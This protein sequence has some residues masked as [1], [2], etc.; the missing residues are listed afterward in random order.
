MT[1][2]IR[3]GQR[4]L[5]VPG[6]GMRVSRRAVSSGSPPSYWLVFD[7]ANDYIT[8]PSGEGSEP[9]TALF[10]EA[11]IKDNPAVS[12]NKEILGR[13]NF[14]ND[15]YALYV[16][17]SATS[18]WLMSLALKTSTGSYTTQTSLGSAV[19]DDLPI[20]IAAGWDGATIYYFVNGIL[21]GT[22]SKGG[23]LVY[24]GSQWLIGAMPGP[25]WPYNAKLGAVHISSVCRHTSSYTIP[26][27]PVADANTVGL[28]LNREGAGTSLADSSGSAHNGT[29]KGAGEP[30]WGD[31]IDLS[32]LSHGDAIWAACLAAVPAVGGTVYLKRISANEYHVF[33]KIHADGYWAKWKLLRTSEAAMGLQGAYTGLTTTDDPSTWAADPSTELMQSGANEYVFEGKI[34]GGS[35]IQW[36]NAHG[37]EV[38]DS[39]GWYVDDVLTSLSDGQYASGSVVE[40]R[41]TL[42]FSDGATRVV[43]VTRSMTI[44]ASKMYVEGSYQFAWLVDWTPTEQIY[45]A[46][47]YYQI[48]NLDTA[49]YVPGGTDYPIATPISNLR[50]HGMAAWKSS[51]GCIFATH[52]D[53]D[54]GVR[55]NSTNGA[56]LDATYRKLYF[57]RTRELY[58]S[59]AGS[60]WAY[61]A[62][63]MALD[64]CGNHFL[65]TT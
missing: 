32:V 30:A 37:G 17:R 45:P 11:W 51:N 22:A 19:F 48:T 52:V 43:D 9:S 23:S 61:T 10:V 65:K 20:Y 56:R 36:G 40:L 34:S 54:G 42:H 6:I 44:D 53:L 64:N 1:T 63:W 3:P 31:A 28:W 38:L 25:V 55:F 33:K 5:N 13:G 47:A 26:T 12:A 15:G 4:V 2:I 18:V 27:A 16:Q 41:A 59:Q 8:L 62:R 24:T 35:N 7:G 50:T 49:T 57:V 39:E 58:G 29:F 60:Q 14:F 21:L 46:M